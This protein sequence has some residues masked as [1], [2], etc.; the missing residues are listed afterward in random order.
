LGGRVHPCWWH[1]L[2]I[3]SVIFTLGCFLRHA[4]STVNGHHLGELP[5]ISFF[6]EDVREIEDWIFAADVALTMRLLR[7]ILDIEIRHEEESKLIARD[8]LF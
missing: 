4:I 8:N 7:D 2:V 5:I 3:V 1:D 6:L